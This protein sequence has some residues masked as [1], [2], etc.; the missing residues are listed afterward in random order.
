MIERKTKMTIE[1]PKMEIENPTF[2]HP[3]TTCPF[4]LASK[5]TCA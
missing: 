5:N 1:I 4:L 2:I 3:T